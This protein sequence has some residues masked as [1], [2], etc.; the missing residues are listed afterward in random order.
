MKNQS[1]SSSIKDISIKHQ[2]F[3]DKFH[4]LERQD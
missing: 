3:K 4:F 2:H 1:Q